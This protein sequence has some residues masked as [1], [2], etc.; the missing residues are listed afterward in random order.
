MGSCRCRG[1]AIIGIVEVVGVGIVGVGFGRSMVCRCLWPGLMC[2]GRMLIR[3]RTCQSAN[4]SL[5][6]YVGMYAGGHEHRLD[7]TM[8]PGPGGGRRKA[9]RITRRG[10]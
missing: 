3:L 6:G 10:A 9:G 1:L 8:K 7:L 5:A 2:V 4:P